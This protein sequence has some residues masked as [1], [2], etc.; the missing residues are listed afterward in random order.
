M[1]A[2]LTNIAHHLTSPATKLASSSPTALARSTRAMSTAARKF[3]FLVVVPDFPG[4]QEK[5]VAI[6]P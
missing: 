2:R 3:E 1:A 6:R 5:R 4:V